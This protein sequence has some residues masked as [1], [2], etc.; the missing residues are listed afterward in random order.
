MLDLGISLMDTDEVRLSPGYHID[1][2]LPGGGSAATGGE[3]YTGWF[4]DGVREHA[5]LSTA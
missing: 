1:A 3:G 4:Q 5:R 2:V